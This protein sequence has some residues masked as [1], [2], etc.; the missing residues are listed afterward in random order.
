[1]KVHLDFETYSECDLKK[2]GA[3]VYSKHPSTRVLF[4]AIRIG[5]ETR[6]FHNEAEI[7]LVIPAVIRGTS[8]MLGKAKKP[9]MNAFNSFFECCII[10][11]VIEKGLIDFSQWRD[12]M[13]QANAAA[14]PGSLGNCAKACGFSDDKLKTA[15]GAELI[16]KLCM[17]QKTKNGLVHPKDRW[18]ERYEP[19]MK[20]LGA[21]CNQDTVVEQAI[22]ETLLPLSD[23]EQKVWQQDQEINWRGMAVDTELC[24]KATEIYLES[25]EHKTERLKQITKL[26]NPNSRNQLLAWL[27]GNLIDIE[28][29]QSATLQ[30]VLQEQ[31][32]ICPMAK[33][34]IE[35]RLHASRT[36]PTKYAKMRAMADT[37]DNRI[38]GLLTYHGASTGRWASRGINTQNLPRPIFNSFKTPVELV[39]DKNVEA[40]RAFYGDEIDVVC[41]TIRPALT[42]KKRSRLIV[43]DYS[44]IESRALSWVTMSQDNLDNI[45]KG[46]IEGD[47]SRVYKIAAAS[48]FD[49]R[50]EDVKK[51]TDEYQGGKAVELACGY[52]GSWMALGQMAEN[53]GVDIQAPVDFVA[54][55]KVHGTIKWFNEQRL[56][57]GLPAMTS[58]QEYQALMVRNWRDN[59][60]NIVN[61]WEDVQACAIV[62][63]EHPG[64]SVEVNKHI[65]FITGK[66]KGIPY[67]WCKLPSGRILSYVN[68]SIKQEGK[69][70]KEIRF[71][72]V[73]STTRR[74]GR[75]Y[76]Y[77]GKL[78]ENIVQAIA[79]DILAY[80]KIRLSTTIYRDMVLS[81]HD[82]IVCEVPNGKGSIEELNEIMCVKEQWMEGFPLRAAGEETEAYW[83]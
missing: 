76:T 20:E 78:T 74:W 71:M 25:K 57:E 6:L 8:I 16:R 73:D 21:Y 53:I 80:T 33:E 44:S 69:Y 35:I 38:R 19:L 10:E 56:S 77:G 52:N 26:S 62:A 11:N 18:G 34:V 37:S 63:I 14:M 61:F 60:P 22:N 17:P 4:A 31:Q 7:K 79:R 72:G 3:W 12:T 65:K 32:D 50:P 39:K 29:L 58:T 46:D 9:E 36:P 42:A 55:S 28:D 54:P 43:S 59:N 66:R 24:E 41:S 75:L 68:P 40:I 51:G 81:V 13:A 2:H 5:K 47:S 15:K 23:D 70:G 1:M 27:H 67:L 49:M 48:V 45:A 30:N 82:E 64:Q 83:K